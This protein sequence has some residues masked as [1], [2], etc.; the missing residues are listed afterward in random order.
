MDGWLDVVEWRELGWETGNGKRYL[1]DVSCEMSLR[2]FFN[3]QKRTKLLKISPSFST[4][5]T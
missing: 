4:I 2:L 1:C 5:V 3:R